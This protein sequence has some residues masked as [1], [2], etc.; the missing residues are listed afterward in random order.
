MKT[1]DVIIRPVITEQSMKIVP[2]GKYTFIVARFADKDAI[3]KAI[4]GLFGVT[5]TGVSTTVIKGRSKRVGARREEVKGSESKKAV[6]TV[7]KGEKIGMFEPGG[8][9]KEEKKK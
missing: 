1:N 2:S 8:E 6:V 4:T 3:K 7:K 5:V 9:I